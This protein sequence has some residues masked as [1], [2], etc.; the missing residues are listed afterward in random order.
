[1]KKIL[2]I[3][4]ESLENPM[5]GTPIRI[6][7]ILLELRKFH[8]VVVSSPS[9]KPGLG[10]FFES[11]PAGG[12]WNKIRYFKQLIR[13]HGVSVVFTSTDIG[14]GI[15]VMLKLFSGVKIVADIHGLYAEEMYFQGL[16]PKWKSILVD[17]KTKFCLRFY[18]LVF[19]VSEKLKEYY[20][21]TAKRIEVLYGGIDPALF[22]DPSRAEP[23]IFTIGYTGN[24][25]SYQGWDTMLE[26][27]ENIK[28][29]NLFPFRLNLVMSSGRGEVEEKLKSLEQEAAGTLEH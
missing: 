29:K 18:D 22:K 8:Q 14:I 19:V 21:R 28:K 3:T 11:Y 6:Y 25:K 1:M 23:E 4:G 17:L 26:A 24:A 2:F 15:P 5:R 12:L 20:R 16:M 27:A 9:I 13:K 7:H 10:I